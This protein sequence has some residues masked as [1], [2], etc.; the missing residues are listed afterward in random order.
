MKKFLSNIFTALV[1]FFVTIGLVFVTAF[2]FWP[3]VALCL[4]VCTLFW[5]FLP[6]VGWIIFSLMMIALIAYVIVNII[7]F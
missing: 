2:M 6:I 4:I 1:V 5:I 7:D 3:F